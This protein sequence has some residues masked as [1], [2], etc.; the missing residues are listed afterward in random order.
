MTLPAIRNPF[1]VILGLQGAGLN[2]GK[3]YIGVDGM[4]PQT[5][6]APVFWDAAGTIPAFQPI[7][8]MGGYLMRA[9]SPASAYVDGRYSIRVRDRLGVQVFYRASAGST[10]AEDRDYLDVYSKDQVYTKEEARVRVRPTNQAPNNLLMVVPDIPEVQKLAI[11]GNGVPTG[12]TRPAA[13]ADLITAGSNTPD[14]RF[15]GGHDF[16]V[17]ELIRAPN[18]ADANLRVA[19]CE[20]LAKTSTTVSIELPD[21]LTV[22]ASSGA[23]GD[24]VA[25]TRGDD[26]GLYGDLM[27]GDDDGSWAKNTTLKVWLE[28]HPS[29]LQY[30]PVNSGRVWLVK[31]GDVAEEAIYFR[32]SADGLAGLHGSKQAVGFAV[33]PLTDGG[34]ATA[35]A[36]NEGVRTAGATFNSPLARGYVG[37]AAVIDGET[38]GLSV[39]GLGF[40]GPVGS[41]FAVAEFTMFQGEP[42]QDGDYQPCVTL[43]RPQG[44]ITIATMNGSTK[45]Y[46]NVADAG[47]FYSYRCRLAQESRGRLGPLVRRM[48]WNLEFRSETAGVLLAT[49]ERPG[50]TTTYGHVG[51]ATAFYREV[52]ISSLW[53]PAVGPTPA[54]IIATVTTPKGHPLFT[55]QAGEILGAA[56]AGFNGVHT[57]TRTGTT[58]WTYRFDSATNPFGGT[59]PGTVT[60]ATKLEAFYYPYAAARCEVNVFDGSFY[61][62]T[63]Q[64]GVTIEFVSMDTNVVYA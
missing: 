58:T 15:P 4:D 51:T 5:N 10:A 28:D 56:Q 16:R 13:T 49:K 17:G 26:T 33:V 12:S 36:Y 7:D 1:E 32:Y 25:V 29:L 18:T 27:S 40:N 30:F 46:P 50:L 11:G 45:T 54:Y 63:V 38:Y 39:L 42:P 43:I 23:N 41:Y 62:Y 19:L 34:S 21:G 8:T 52:T 64:P 60:S 3:V 20:V 37:H 14:I 44:S 47:G 2:G 61:H 55:G 22:A 6:P 53:N 9:G 59:N 24:W 48:N 57:A 31:K 35:I